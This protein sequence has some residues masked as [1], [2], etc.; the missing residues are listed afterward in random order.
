M[1]ISLTQLTTYGKVA[2]T[3]FCYVTYTHIQIFNA[4]RKS[5]S[6]QNRRH[7]QSLITGAQRSNLPPNFHIMEDY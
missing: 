7:G 3:S 4:H 5:V 1:D 2:V 6:R